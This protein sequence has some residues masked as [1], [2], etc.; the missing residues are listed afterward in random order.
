M[1]IKTAVSTTDP[2]VLYPGWLSGGRGEVCPLVKKRTFGHSEVLKSKEKTGEKDLL[3][4]RLYV[5]YHKV[6]LGALEK[7]R[8]EKLKIPYKKI[9]R[10]KG[11]TVD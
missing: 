6:V 2:S 3:M 1:I 11:G 9:C 5:G 8:A 7:Y 10:I 4:N